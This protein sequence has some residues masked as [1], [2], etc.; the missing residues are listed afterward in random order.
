MFALAGAL[1]ILPFSV[2]FTIDNSC[3]LFV[4]VID[5]YLFKVK[6][7]RKQV[8]AV[9]WGFVGVLLTVNGGFLLSLINPELEKQTEFKNYLTNDPY[10]KLLAGCGFVFVNFLR[11]YSLCIIKLIKGMKGVEQS[12][13]LSAFMMMTFGIA[14]FQML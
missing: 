5:Y 12:F 13:Q 14:Y 1:F 7:N 10:L 11:A 8:Y 4:F 6:I 3:A 9:I 2:A